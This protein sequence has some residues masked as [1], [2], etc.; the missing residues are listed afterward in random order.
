MM[1]IP[2]IDLVD[3]KVVR[4][5]RGDINKM[6]VYSLNPLEVARKFLD[7]G[8]KILHVVDI[9]A[10]LGIGNN[11]E[12]VHKIVENNI[13]IQ[14]GGG[15]RSK[16]EVEELLDLGV[17]RVVVSTLAFSNPTLTKQ[18]VS[19]YNERLAVSIDYAKNKVAIK[20]WKNL[21]DTSPLE[22]AKNLSSIGF[23]YIILTSVERDG[24]LLGAD[25]DF[26]NKAIKEVS[27]R[28]IFSGGI[29]SIEEIKKLKEIGVYGAILGKSIYEGKIDLREAIK[30]GE[31]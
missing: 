21:I 31:S 9:S 6:K 23:K 26:V 25:F 22:L 29:F 15:I 28:L 17:K 4:L 20:G 13:P 18:L 1:V 14:L 10:A 7:S 30:V 5:T 24:T 16:N 3:G 19:L 12:V 27:A 11:R 2:S 8:A